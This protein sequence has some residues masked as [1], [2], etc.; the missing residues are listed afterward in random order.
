MSGAHE[1]EVAARPGTYVDRAIRPIG[2][3][4]CT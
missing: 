2:H 3:T 1:R 4:V